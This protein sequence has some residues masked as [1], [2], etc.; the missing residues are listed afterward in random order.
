[1]AF[2]TAGLVCIVGIVL[3]APV[4]WKRSPV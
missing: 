1:V 3:V 4:A 2:V